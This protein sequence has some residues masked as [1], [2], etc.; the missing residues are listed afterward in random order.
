MSLMHRL[1]PNAS[2]RGIL[3]SG[4]A[5]ATNV[6][7]HGTADSERSYKSPMKMVAKPLLYRRDGARIAVGGQRKLRSFDAAYI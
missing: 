1:R 4:P 5:G 2:V 3:P 6:R 7:W